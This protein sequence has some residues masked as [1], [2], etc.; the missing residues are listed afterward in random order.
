M[1]KCNS[2]S[3]QGPK[4]KTLKENINFLSEGMEYHITNNIPLCE[5]TFRPY[6]SK[7]F[8]LFREARNLMEMNIIELNETDN[9]I[10]ETE[11][12]NFGEYNG[13]SVPLDCI[14]DIDSIIAEAEYKG[15]KV[16]LNKPKR[17]GSKK[18]YVFT[19]NPKTGKVIKVSF[20]MA[21]GGLK[22]KLNDPK[23]RQSFSKR[24]DCPNAKDK[25]KP[26]YWACRLPRYSKLIGINTTFTGYW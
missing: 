5:N 3:I 23:A 6:S 2:D 25:T 7:Y 8:S 13:L 19:K 16:E 4:L 15:K 18:F 22:V 21:G 14:L 17:G 20:G 1:C 11:I 12:G 24:M 10:L 9:E 26:K